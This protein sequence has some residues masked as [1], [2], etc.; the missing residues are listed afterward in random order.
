MPALK[1]W[2]YVV[3]TVVALGS[4][5]VVFGWAFDS[6][7]FDWAFVDPPQAASP[8]KRSTTRRVRRASKFA[9]RTR[10]F[11]GFSV[12]SAIGPELILSTHFRDDLMGCLSC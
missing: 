3:T 9:F 4:D 2:R 11:I 6:V 10:R 5:G 12:L 7:V 1:S 8:L